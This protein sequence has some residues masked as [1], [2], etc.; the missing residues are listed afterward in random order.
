MNVQVKSFTGESAN[1]Y[2]KDLAQLRIEVF[3]EFPYLYDGN[4]EYEEKYLD[5]FMQ[6]EDSIIVVAFNRDKVVGVSTGIP[7]INEP[8]E[9]REVWIDKGY[10]I[11]D[12]FYFSESVLK[13]NYRGHGIGVTF[14]EQREQWATKLGYGSAIFCGVIRSE[15]HPLKPEG[16]VNLESFWANRGYEKKKGFQCSMSWKDIDQSNESSKSLQFW[17]KSL[18]SGQ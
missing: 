17:S 10:D 7:L 13:K 1:I 8:I 18:S 2:K 16:Y 5:T 12:I 6:A 9:I 15:N 3:R 14:F 11:E 4:M